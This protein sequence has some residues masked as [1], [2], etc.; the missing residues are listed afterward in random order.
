MKRPA[1]GEALPLL[2][3][4]AS[5]DQLAP[6]RPAAS[7][8]TISAMLAPRAPPKG[9]RL[10]AKAARASVVGWPAGSSAQPSG[11]PRPASAEARREAR[12]AELEARSS[13]RAGASWAG[14]QVGE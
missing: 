3:G 5:F 14:R 6:V 1:P 9:S 4:G 11:I 12:E 7:S 13:N 2:K 8:S 10:P